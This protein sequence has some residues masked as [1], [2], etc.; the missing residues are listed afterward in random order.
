MFI[1]IY[2]A[3]GGTLKS[4]FSVLADQFSVL[5]PDGSGQ[6][7]LPLVFQGGVLKLQGVKVQWADIENAV[8]TWAQIGSAVINNAVFGTTNIDYN[9]VTASVSNGAS[10]TG[11]G[12]TGSETDFTTIGTFSLNNENPSAVMTQLQTSFN[13]TSASSTA[14][15]NAY[16]RLVNVTN[17]NIVRQYQI[18]A[19]PRGN[20]SYNSPEFLLEPAPSSR[21]VK[22]YQI[23]ISRY[24]FNTS[25]TVTQQWWKR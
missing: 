5:N 9:A 1:E 7:F 25:M 8:I 20:A 3:G 21:G 15:R 12:N 4:R 23:Q 24:A 11:P 10:G 18:T 19:P 17:G 6:S 16:V 13:A 22:T 14:S 2:N